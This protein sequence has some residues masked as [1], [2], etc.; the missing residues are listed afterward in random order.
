MVVP[1]LEEAV[2]EAEREVVLVG[3]GR[4]GALPVPQQ[5]A[6]LLLPRPRASDA[7][8]KVVGRGSERVSGT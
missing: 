4:V 2:D 3:A 6:L 1:E 7:Q 8:N 5:H